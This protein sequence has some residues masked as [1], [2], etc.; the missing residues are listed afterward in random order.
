[1]INFLPDTYNFNFSQTSLDLTGGAGALDN[2]NVEQSIVQEPNEEEEKVVVQPSTNEGPFGNE[3]ICF[4]N[5][6]GPYKF[7]VSF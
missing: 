3:N 5:Y 7:E 4:D 2:N 6:P 1:V